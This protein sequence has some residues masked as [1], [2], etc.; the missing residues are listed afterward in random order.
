MIHAPTIT[1][2]DPCPFPGC[3]HAFHR[4]EDGPRNEHLIKAHPGFY[5]TK[6]R[7]IGLHAEASEIAQM[8]D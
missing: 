2:K 3:E 7:E 1:T 4:W 6:L 8:A 5:I